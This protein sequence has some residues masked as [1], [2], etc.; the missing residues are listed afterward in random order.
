MQQSPSKDSTDPTS[1]AALPS[2][3]ALP[4]RSSIA[5]KPL[6]FPRSASVATPEEESDEPKNPMIV[7][8]LAAR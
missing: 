8:Y 5:P 1:E 2:E 4:G 7:Y 6:R 3:Y